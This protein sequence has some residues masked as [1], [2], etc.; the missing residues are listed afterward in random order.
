[1]K[2]WHSYLHL[3][4]SCR[5]HH[6][7]VRILMGKGKDESILAVTARFSVC[8]PTSY[9]SVCEATLVPF[10]LW[11]DSP[12]QLLHR[13]D[14][15]RDRHLQGEDR[16]LKPSQHRQSYSVPLVPCSCKMESNCKTSVTNAIQIFTAKL[17]SEMFFLVHL[18][19]FIAERRQLCSAGLATI[20]PSTSAVISQWTFPGQEIRTQSE[21][22]S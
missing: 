5:G 19:L 16:A 13:S 3:P 22:C 20:T 8:V 11:W 6:Q 4:A 14:G 10:R 21:N 9:K 17:S 1:M 12:D 7:Q 18:T 2:T 15:S